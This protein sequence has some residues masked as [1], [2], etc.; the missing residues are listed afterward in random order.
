MQSDLVGATLQ[1]SHS[2]LQ[3]KGEQKS[4]KIKQ[5]KIKLDYKR[6][7]R[8]KVITFFKRGS[9]KGEKHWHEHEKDWMGM[10]IFTSYMTFISWGLRCVFFFL[11]FP[12][13]F[14]IYD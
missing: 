8:W 9:A 12:L 1:D 5:S 13:K 4:R 7:R 3:Q 6:P 2:Q 10:S 11:I 14:V